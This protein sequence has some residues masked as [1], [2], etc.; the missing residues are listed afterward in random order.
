LSAAE[1]V[2]GTA[3]AVGVVEAGVAAAHAGQA[4]QTAGVGVVLP[5]TGR[6]AAAVEEVVPAIALLAV[7]AGGG[8]AGTGSLAGRAKQPRIV[9][10]V[11]GRTVSDAGVVEQV[12][13]AAGGA[14]GSQ[15]AAPFAGVLASLADRGVIAI[16]A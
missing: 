16:V 6:Q 4:D 11:A 13:V 9:L 8:A 12:A 7:G 15:H 3:E 14:V 1:E 5:R 2:A 10:E